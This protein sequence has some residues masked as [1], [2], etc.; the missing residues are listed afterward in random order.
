MSRLRLGLIIGAF[1]AAGLVWAGR[2]AHTFRL[3]YRVDLSSLP[4]GAKRTKLW[5]PLPSNRQHQSVEAQRIDC[6]WPYVVRTDPD[7]G[8]RYL[9]VDVE[10]PL[11]GSP[12]VV[13]SSLIRRHEVT[14]SSA[15]DQ[16]MSGLKRFLRSDKLVPLSKPLRRE[17]AQALAAAEPGDPARALYDH[18]VRSMRYDKTVPGWGQGDAL[19]ACDVR[20]GN[21]TD[22]HSLFTG[23]A[24]AE[25]IPARFIMGLPLPKS[26]E[27]PIAGYHCWAEFWKPG[28]GWVPVDASEA[29]KDKARAGDYFGRLDAW[30][31]AVSV[32]RDIQLE[33]APK[34]GRLNYFIHPLVEVDGRAHPEVTAKISCK[35]A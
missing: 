14:P 16:D 33:P 17:A 25:G 15:L 1:L 29:S 23:L 35:R 8:N 12:A 30:R 7:Y 20:A 24:R 9:F 11:A 19:R 10:G 13:V 22:F 34:G 26:G 6:P 4:R 5:L 27:G 18:V 21:C 28:S 2:D 32:G 3:E 31:V